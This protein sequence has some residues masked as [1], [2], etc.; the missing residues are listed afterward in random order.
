MSFDPTPLSREEKLL[1]EQC[2]QLGNI[3]EAVRSISFTQQ[4]ADLDS[5]VTELTTK[6]A[7]LEAANTSLVSAVAAVQA[8]V[9]AL[10]SSG[11]GSSESEPTHDTLQEIIDHL[12]IELPSS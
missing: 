10:Q 11:G 1:A 2:V 8:L 6:I 12:N 3:T 7:T 9:T 5:K 4:N